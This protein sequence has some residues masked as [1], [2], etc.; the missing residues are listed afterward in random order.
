MFTIPDPD[1]IKNLAMMVFEQREKQ[2]YP[3][4]NLLEQGL[5][6]KPN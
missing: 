1:R 3:V 6:P 2:E 4:K 5:E